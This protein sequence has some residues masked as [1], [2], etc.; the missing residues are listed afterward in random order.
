M[1]FWIN[2]FNSL[3]ILLKKLNETILSHNNVSRFIFHMFGFEFTGGG[4]K[5]V[6]WIRFTHMKAYT[7]NEPVC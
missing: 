4:E 6:V 1:A 2:I 5:V 7:E 3:F